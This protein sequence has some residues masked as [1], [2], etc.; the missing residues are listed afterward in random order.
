MMK[1]FFKIS[2]KET[3]GTS[4]FLG[5]RTSSVELWPTPDG[6]PAVRY[7]DP[8]ILLFLASFAPFTSSTVT[9]SSAKLF[10]PGLAVAP[11]CHNRYRSL[12]VTAIERKRGEMGSFFILRDVLQKL[13]WFFKP[14]EISNKI[15]QT[16]QLLIFT[17]WTQGSR[18]HHFFSAG[19]YILTCTYQI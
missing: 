17:C 7:M 9:P 16:R 13:G 4:G 19:F 10:T 2:I 3:L 12:W 8:T 18:F 14:K 6:I 5:C 15:Q 1:Y 11:S